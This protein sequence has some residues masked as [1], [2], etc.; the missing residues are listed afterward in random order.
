M[1]LQRASRFA[2]YAV[3]ELAR[4]GDRQ[5]TAAEIARKYGISINHLAKVLRDLGRAGLVESVRGVGGGFRF[6]GDAK[7]TTLMEVI[8][9]FET[10]GSN[11]P[12]AAREPGE[13]TEIGQ[14]MRR[15][16]DEID[17]ITQA[18]LRSITLDTLF[19]VIER[20]RT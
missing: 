7:R 10:I 17:E 15:V 18:T 20:R 8:E 1:R 11:T 16:L 4:A 13:D 2:L 14:A 12:H 9:L 5:I 3:L 19:K 6:S